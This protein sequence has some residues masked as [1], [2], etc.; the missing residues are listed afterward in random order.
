[1]RTAVCEVWSGRAGYIGRVAVIPGISL[2]CEV[3]KSDE[4]E[5]DSERCD[6]PSSYCWHVV[7][8]RSIEVQRGG[9]LEGVAQRQA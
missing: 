3:V 8:C 2:V 4:C 1:M 5:N 6:A 7:C 9:K